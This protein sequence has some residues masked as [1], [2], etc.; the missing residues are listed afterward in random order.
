MGGSLPERRTKV[1][2]ELVYPAGSVGAGGSVT[3]PRLGVQ[4]GGRRNVNGQ[5][6]WDGGPLTI[7]LLFLRATLILRK[8]QNVRPAPDR[9]RLLLP[10]ARRGGRHLPPIV[11]CR[12]LGRGVGWFSSR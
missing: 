1:L 2:I 8:A 5:G 3:V 7:I 9:P 4:G 10:R 11:S 6:G 12:K